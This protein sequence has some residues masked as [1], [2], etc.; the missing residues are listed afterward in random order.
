MRVAISLIVGIGVLGLVG[1]GTHSSESQK[2]QSLSRGHPSSKSENKEATL[3]TAGELHARRPEKSEATKT[4]SSVDS[5]QNRRSPP[6]PE[7]CRQPPSAPRI[8]AHVFPKKAVLVRYELPGKAIASRCRVTAL[9]IAVAMGKESKF[10]SLPPVAVAGPVGV[11]NLP[12]M[13]SGAIRL[14]IAAENA[15]RVR[16]RPM[17][18]WLRP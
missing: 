18:R 14:R 15:G 9:N 17:I 13:T 10:R 5:K 11:V 2:T 6:V 3:A 8:Q 1:C 4:S 12:D 16:G 7:I